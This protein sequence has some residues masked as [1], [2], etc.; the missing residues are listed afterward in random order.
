LLVERL[1]TRTTS[2]WFHD[3][4]AA[5]IPSGPIHD[6]GQGVEFAAEIGLDPVVEIGEGEGMVPT[7]R[8][9]ITFS[10]TPVDYRL[11]PPGLDEQ[12]EAIRAWLRDTPA[13]RD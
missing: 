9:P 2:E 4:V 7:V 10:Q 13:D 3:I 1:A 12:G 11:P 8:N 6:V 5:G